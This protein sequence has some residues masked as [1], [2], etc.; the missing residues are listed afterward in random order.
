MDVRSE[1]EALH[2]AS[3]GWALACTG[4]DRERASDVLQQAYW[5]V[6]DG[7]ARWDGRATFKTWFFGVVRITALEQRRWFSR[8]RETEPL[9]SREIPGSAPAPDSAMARLERAKRLSAALEQIA[10]R[11][12]EVLHLVFYEDMSIAEAAVV[13]NVSLGSARQHYDRGKKRLEEL[14]R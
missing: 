7:R 8:R 13:M 9:S 1:L 10:P 5:K 2:A 4:R 14:L 3:F 6:L 12:R 11:Q